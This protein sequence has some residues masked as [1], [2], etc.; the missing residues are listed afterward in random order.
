MECDI[1]I[2]PV[3]SVDMKLI[4]EPSI[5]KELSDYFTFKVP[6]YQFM[7]SYRNKMWDGTIKLYNLYKQTLYRGLEK[8][9]LAFA[10]ERDYTVRS[11]IK[12]KE[13]KITFNDI[14]PFIEDTIKP[15]INGDTINVYFYH[16]R[17]LVKVSSS[18]VYLDII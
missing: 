12:K 15:S 5:A 17:V 16:Q 18:I 14:K 1:I 7:P 10:K 13:S 4:C 9:I 8:Y 3:D 11:E 2:Q 6:G